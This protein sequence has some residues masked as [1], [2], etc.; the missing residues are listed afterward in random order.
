MRL[1]VCE[2]VGCQTSR[3]IE[4][5]KTSAAI[6]ACLK[7][8]PYTD[9]LRKELPISACL[10]DNS[11][12]VQNFFTNTLGLPTGECQTHTTAIANGRNNGSHKKNFDSMG[13]Y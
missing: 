10:G 8:S 1:P 9:K 13:K 7:G 6:V 4:L 3:S 5:L 11:F 12:A 2:D